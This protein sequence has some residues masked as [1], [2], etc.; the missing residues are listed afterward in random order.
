MHSVSLQ[1]DIHILHY[2]FLEKML[3]CGDAADTELTPLQTAT[4]EVF[5]RQTLWFAGPM[6]TRRERLLPPRSPPLAP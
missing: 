2:L 3:Q 1:I 4:S 6:K 5:L